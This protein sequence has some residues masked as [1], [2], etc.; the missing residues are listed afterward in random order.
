MKRAELDALGGRVEEWRN[1][2][3]TSSSLGPAE[4]DWVVTSLVFDCIASCAS[5]GEVGGGR[6]GHGT[7]DPE[8]GGPGSCLRVWQAERRVSRTDWTFNVVEQSLHQ[9]GRPLVVVSEGAEMRAI[10][11]DVGTGPPLGS[12]TD[13]DLQW[14]HRRVHRWSCV[15]HEREY[16]EREWIRC[17][18]RPVNACLSL[19]DPGGRR[20]CPAALWSDLS[21]LTS[22]EGC[23]KCPSQA[24]PWIDDFVGQ[25]TATHGKG[26][27]RDWRL[28]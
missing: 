22:V 11:L 27:G 10:V 16:E 13:Y 12:C 18:C 7:L 4:L 2:R 15:V 3:Q 23:R 17:E 14:Q 5:S 9:A 6:G 19:A 21:T 26:P 8:G 24:V 25:R 1:V 28:Y 20:E